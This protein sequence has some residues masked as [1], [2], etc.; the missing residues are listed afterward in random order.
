M[1]RFFSIALCF[2]FIAS[3][4]AQ[5]PYFPHR[6]AAFRGGGGSATC[7]AD[8]SPDIAVPAQNDDE[9]NV[10]SAAERI[11]IG[12]HNFS[13]STGGAKDVCKL[14]FYNG[15]IIGTISGKAYRASVWTLTGNNLNA[16]VGD[17]SDEITGMTTAGWKRFTFSG[18]KPQL[19]NGTSYALVVA[20]YDV[21]TTTLSSPDASNYWRVWADSPSSITGNA[22]GWSAAGGSEVNSGTVD[23]CIEVYWYD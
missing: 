8:G 19:A 5:S 22:G 20:T 2:A 10:G 9:N 1:K 3:T 13:Q 12:Q 18:T 7:P 17:L 15:A 4:F 23:S 11:Y 21:G 6:R 16:R 14:G